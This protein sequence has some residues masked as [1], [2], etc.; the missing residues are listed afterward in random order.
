MFSIPSLLWCVGVLSECSG[1]ETS[2]LELAGCTNSAKAIWP[3]SILYHNSAGVI[4]VLFILQLA[5]GLIYA[6][7]GP[8]S[9]EVKI[10]RP[11][12]G[13]NVGVQYSSVLHGEAAT[14]IS[15]QPAGTASA[16]RW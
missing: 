7:L 15:I 10:Q 13:D 4:Q 16:V 14:K 9:Q 5:P 8:N 3:S 12:S 1:V 11:P 2:H 6:E